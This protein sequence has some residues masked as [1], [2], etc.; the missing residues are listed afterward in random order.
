MRMRFILAAAALVAQ[1]AAAEPVAIPVAMAPSIAGPVSGRL[2]VF[3]RKAASGEKAPAAVDGSPFSPTET[4]VAAREVSALSPGE[5]ATVDAET[6]SFPVAFSKL[7]P[8]TY[9]FQAVLDR[10][11]DYN[12]GGRGAGD[13]VSPVV[14]ARLPGLVP[15]LVLRDVLPAT[16]LRA[17]F[18]ALPEAERAP[19]IAAYDAAR[20]VDFV[21]ARLSAFWGR[22]IR[23]RGWVAL[24]PGYDPRGRATYPTVYATGGFGSSAASARFAAARMIGRMRA[25]K[26]PPMIWV[27]LDESSPTGTHEFAD[28]VN[29]GPWGE[30]LTTELIPSLEKT[31]R[32]DARASGRFLNG[33]SSGG[34][35]TLWLQTR[36]PKLFGGTWS[37]SPDPS[38][39]HDFTGIDIYAPGANAYVNTAGQP[40]PLVR[41][42]GRELASVQDFAR[43]E[44]VLGAYGGQFSSFDW[45]FS[46]KGPDG[47]PLPLF[48]R[49]TGRVDPAVAAYWRDHYDIAHRIAR[50]WPAL[51][52]DLDGKIHVFVGTADTFH[53]DG[54][55]HRL[56]AVLASLG[57]RAH[58]EFL[59]G[60]THFDVYQANGDPSGLFDRIAAEMY[61]V[62]RPQR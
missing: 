3:A 17:G 29:N 50:D 28:S 9:R 4:A 59:P 61:A 23:M 25:G 49:A 41:D 32:M 12:Y 6:D 52:P 31:Y 54:S 18:A 45:V 11:H 40:I 8:G 21:S 24:P 33:H 5:T 19:A 14:E 2:I 27:L 39:F 37:T 46:P 1:P 36:Y 22:P 48:D 57:A 55:A 62:A 13:I 7:A 43:L 30:A 34:W 16:D 44:A 38:D 10:N 58:F 20:P 51:R 35:A 42:K 53:L 47:R 60:R 56:Q 15:P 26:M